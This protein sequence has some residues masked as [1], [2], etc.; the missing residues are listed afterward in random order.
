MDERDNTITAPTVERTLVP[1]EPDEIEEI[2][3]EEAGEPETEHLQ[4]H[5]QLVE[6][7]EDE[8]EG[9]LVIS[10][11]QIAAANDEMRAAGLPEFDIDEY[12]QALAESG[13]E[14]LALA[15][16]DLPAFISY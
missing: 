15:E 12:M 16:A 4:D 7:E 11:E 6:A 14:G 9:S 3:S 2:E 1:V 8:E 13:A 10:D 5:S